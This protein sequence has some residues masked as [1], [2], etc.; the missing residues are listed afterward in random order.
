MKFFKE[1]SSMIMRMIITHIAMSVFGLAIFFATNLM[2]PPTIMLAASIFSAVFFG[3]IVYTTMWEY[4]A[5][6]KPAFD[7]GR[8]VGAGK[9]GFL[10]ML[11]AEALWIILAV[12]YVCI[13][14]FDVNIAS[15]VYVVEFL[16]TCC[17][18]G[19]EVYL[20]NYVVANSVIVPAL[21]YIA[22]SLII[23]AVGAFGYVLG[24]KDLTIIPKKANT[25]K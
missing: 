1:N 25:K 7:A 11:S 21:V 4:G 22:G 20:K 14:Q 6:D 12:A 13:Y 17:F 8:Q 16:T 5:K 2:N 24:T 15:I 18:T 3:I 10:T 23:C 9:H 19:I